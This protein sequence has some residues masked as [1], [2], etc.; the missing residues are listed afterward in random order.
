MSGIQHVSLRV[1]AEWDAGWFRHFITEVL[2]KAD[3]RNAA[4]HGLLVQSAGNSVAV[5]SVDAGM[6]ALAGLADGGGGEGEPGPPGP[7]GAD[8]ADGASRDGY[9]FFLAD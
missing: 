4:G 2:A 1:P 7:A 6:A 3:V 9:A 5:L 8:G